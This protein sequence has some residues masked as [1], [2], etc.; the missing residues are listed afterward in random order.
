MWILFAFGSA[1]FAGLTAILAK[2]GIHN[3]DSNLATAIRTIVVLVSSCLMVFIVGSQETIHDID[4]KTLLFLVLSG[5]A[6]GASWLCYF[7]ALQL[8]VVNKV[9]PID[10][11]SVILT[12]VLAI[13]FL[14][15]A[16]SV[17]KITGIAIIGIGTFLMTY[18]RQI[19]VKQIAGRQWLVYAILSAVFASMTSILAKVGIQGVESN[20]GTAIRTVVVLIMAWMMV[21]IVKKQGEIRH[22]DNKSW[23]FI[24][25]SGIATGA[26]WLCFYR[27]LQTG[28]ASVVVPIDKLSIVFTVAFS[29]FILKEKLTR[30]S[31]TGLVLIVTGTLVLLV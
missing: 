26:S 24:C 1:V 15:E 28:P 11:S 18:T 8:G 23:A 27:A 30:R 2:L 6:T 10:R 5:I 14:S 25:L 31:F 4:S 9:A 12:I 21:Y 7:K 22:I 20:L 3:V 13:I 16:V 29:F 19:S 17:S